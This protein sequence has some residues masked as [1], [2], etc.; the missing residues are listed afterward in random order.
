[1]EISYTN[2]RD[3]LIS[4]HMG[5]YTETKIYRMLIRYYL[6]CTIAGTLCILLMVII[7]TG[8][9]TKIIIPLIIA[10]PILILLMKKYLKSFFYKKLNT[11]YNYKG[12]NNYFINTKLTISRDY[13][14]LFTDLDRKSYSWKAIYDICL[15]GNYIFITTTS[16]DDILIPLSC[17]TSS[18]EVNSFL[19]IILKCTNLELKTNYPTD[20]RY[21]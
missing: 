18:D 13:L 1:M 20:I 2:S 10:D 4:F 5:H 16:H 9:Y 6:E 12:T 7:L 3:D 8:T 17:F 15:I 11:I 21:Q 19:T 14:N